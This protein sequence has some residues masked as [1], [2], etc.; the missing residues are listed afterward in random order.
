MPHDFD[1]LVDLEVKTCTNTKTMDILEGVKK[2]A[3]KTYK[4]VFRSA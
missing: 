1:H 4:S 3:F 2:I